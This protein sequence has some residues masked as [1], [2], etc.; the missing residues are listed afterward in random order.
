MSDSILLDS[1][2][3]FKKNNS[4]A[5][6]ISKKEVVENFDYKDG[7]LFWRKKISNKINAGS[8]AGHFY[9]RPDRVG[10]RCK[11]SLNGKKYFRSRLVWVM[12]F[13]EIPEGI[14][15]D[16]IDRNVSND[17]IENLRLAT[18]SENNIN[19]EMKISNTSGFRGI[20]FCK[21]KNKWLA[22]IGLN[23]KQ[24]RIGRFKTKEEAYQAYL[25]S[26]REFHGIWNPISN[27][28][29]EK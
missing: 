16:H 18:N 27:A 2:E 22:E 23:G 5:K 21:N 29:I 1:F 4:I 3:E 26:A 19:K 14:Q 24:Y 12:H 9:S 8:E 11:I 20:Y 25:K 13:G 17:R 28:E 6:K 15:I 10:K 7:K